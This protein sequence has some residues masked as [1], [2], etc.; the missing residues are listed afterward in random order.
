MNVKPRPGAMD[1]PR[2]RVRRGLLD[3]GRPQNNRIPAVAPV[4][5]EVPIRGANRGL[6]MDFSQAHDA[7]ISK[8][9]RR[10][11]VLVQQFSNGGPRVESA[12]ART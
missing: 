1:Y 7:S 5:L 4:E 11:R 3:K 12:V 8:I 2:K 9:H 6:R 10:I